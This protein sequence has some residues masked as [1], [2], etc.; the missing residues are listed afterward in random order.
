[1]R[2]HTSLTEPQVREALTR[3]QETGHV[4]GDVTFTAFSQRTSRTHPRAFEVS[5]GVPKEVLYIP[6]PDGYADHRG[7]PQKKRCTARDGVSWAAT[8]HEWGWLI[9]AVFDAD[10]SSRWGGKSWGYDDRDDF[11][12]KT[13]YVFWDVATVT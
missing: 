7:K 1:M 6:L 11:D 12:Q 5:L 10:P 13:G 8:W 9:S 3:A 2:L 4:A